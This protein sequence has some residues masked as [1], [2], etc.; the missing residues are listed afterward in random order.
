MTLPRLDSILRQLLG[1]GVQR[2]A[3]PATEVSAW[4]KDLHRR[5]GHEP[6][7]VSLAELRAAESLTDG[8]TWADAEGAKRI[9]A[10]WLKG[11][12]K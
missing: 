2:Y 8:R 3:E 7:N 1:N 10:A 4:L 11:R 12:V 6:W 9:H 5:C